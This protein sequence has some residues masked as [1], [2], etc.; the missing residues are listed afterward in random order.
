MRPNPP[1][2][3]ELN[4]NGYTMMVLRSDSTNGVGDVNATDDSDV[5]VGTAPIPG[6]PKIMGQLIYDV[7]SDR[8]R[9]ADY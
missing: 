1:R 3:R 5:F 7:L 8:S 2:R 6:D 4:L 9:S